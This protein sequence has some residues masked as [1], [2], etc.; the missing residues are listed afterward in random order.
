[1]P[2]ARAMISSGPAVTRA[3]LARVTPA[4]RT[5]ERAPCGARREAADLGRGLLGGRALDRR[6]PAVAVPVGA[7]R[8]DLHAA[9]LPLLRLRDPELEHAL[10]QLGH[11]Q[12]G[13][14]PL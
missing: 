4:S 9:R 1:M 12:L 14:D 2:P 10:V 11:H 13:V 5:C 3:R 8:A 6:G 7:G